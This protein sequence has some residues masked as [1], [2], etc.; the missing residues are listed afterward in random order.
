MSEGKDPAALNGA[1]R[2]ANME[3]CRLAIPRRTYTESHMI[4]VLEI[5]QIVASQKNSL[6]GY[7]IVQQPQFLRHFSS[8][9]EPL[10]SPHN[11]IVP[12]HASAGN[13]IT[14]KGT[15]ASV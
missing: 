3:L 5:A 13:G 7:R 1:D 4:Y 9:L 14:E 2:T 11:G 15:A 8:T 12:F 10:D 6:K